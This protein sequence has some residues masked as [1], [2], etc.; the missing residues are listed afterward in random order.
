MILRVIEVMFKLLVFVMNVES[1]LAICVLQ[2][3]ITV[4]NSCRSNLERG[5]ISLCSQFIACSQKWAGS[6]ALVLR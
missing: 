1:W 6:T 5:G 4:T 3:F 2:I